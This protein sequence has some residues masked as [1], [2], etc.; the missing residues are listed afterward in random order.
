MVTAVGL[1]GGLCTASTPSSAA[2]R[3]PMPSS[4]VP[5]GRV[6]P[7]PAIVTHANPQHTVR[8]ADV[9]PRHACT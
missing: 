9:D 1:P 5:R 3:R 7:A 8:A 4:P 6:G 2:T